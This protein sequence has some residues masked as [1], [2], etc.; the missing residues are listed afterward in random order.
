MGLDTLEL[1][2]ETEE[3]FGVS[4]PDKEASEIR[5]VGDLHEAVLRKL[6]VRNSQRCLTA[7]AFYRLRRALVELLGV[8]REQVRPD[9]SVGDVLPWYRRRQL[10]PLLA[11]G[12]GLRMPTLERPEWLREAIMSAAVLTFIAAPVLAAMGG[13]SVWA[14]WLLIAIAVAL[15]FCVTR[16]LALVPAGRCRT[17]GDLARAVYGVNAGAL[18]REAGEVNRAETWGM[19]VGLVS[20]QLGVRE[21]DITPDSRF[22]EDLNCG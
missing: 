22:I 11:S 4:I 20:D 16:P 9:R 15:A 1:L 14:V 12:S 21:R 3:R 18:A 2:L 6:S 10:W 7:M 8:R 5:T 17:V 13:L 19:L